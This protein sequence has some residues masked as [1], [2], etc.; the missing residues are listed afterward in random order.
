MQ[1]T[2]DHPCQVILRL[3]TTLGDTK[4]L[5][6]DGSQFRSRDAPPASTPAA[7]AVAAGFFPTAVGAALRRVADGEVASDRQRNLGL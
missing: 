3:S 5:T 7:S 4:F 6:H 2:L 1:A